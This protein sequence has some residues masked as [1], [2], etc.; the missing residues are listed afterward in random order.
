MKSTCISSDYG[1]KK[2]KKKKKKQVKSFKKIGIKL[3]EELCS[4]GIHCLYIV[5]EKWLSSQC[6]NK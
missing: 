1:K 3:F 4:R 6:G 2:K 5:G